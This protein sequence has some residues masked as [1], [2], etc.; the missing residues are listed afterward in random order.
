MSNIFTISNIEIK[1]SII[2]DQDTTPYDYPDCYDDK[3]IQGWKND[4]WCFVGI[5]AVAE[6]TLKSDTG[7]KI[8]SEIVSSGLFGIDHDYCDGS[9]KYL[10]N[11][12]DNQINEILL[13][14]DKT[15]IYLKDFYIGLESDRVCPIP[16]R[17]FDD[18]KACEI[19]T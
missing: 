7:F 10:S 9:W 8:S 6:I 2:Y 4:A 3:D 19:T 16:L 5:K 14:L 15:G 12:Y 18:L 17:I 1:P 11:E 13:D